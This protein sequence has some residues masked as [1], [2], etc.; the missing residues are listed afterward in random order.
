MRLCQVRISGPVSE[1]KRCNISQ[2][3]FSRAEHTEMNGNPQREKNKYMENL[4]EYKADSA[5][6]YDT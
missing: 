5:H 6:F 3:F 2:R 1:I 4:P